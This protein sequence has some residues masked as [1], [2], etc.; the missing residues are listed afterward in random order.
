MHV[1]SNP[2]LISFSGADAQ[3]S[4]NRIA[5]LEPKPMHDYSEVTPKLIN[6]TYSQVSVDRIEVLL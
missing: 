1:Y 4:E 6:E 5:A 3:V 2:S